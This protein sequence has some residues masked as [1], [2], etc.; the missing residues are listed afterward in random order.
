MPFQTNW[1]VIGKRPI[2]HSTKGLFFARELS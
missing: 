2:F 1:S